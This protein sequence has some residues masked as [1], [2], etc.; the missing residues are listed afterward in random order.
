MKEDLGRNS[1]GETQELTSMHCRTARRKS[2]NVQGLFG[3]TSCEDHSSWTINATSSSGTSIRS[4]TAVFNK[5]IDRT[6]RKDR[7]R[8]EKEGE[9]KMCALVRVHHIEAFSI[10]TSSEIR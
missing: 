8:G 3:I 7:M 10:Q 1:H 6:R 4:R 9:K 5:N 2:R